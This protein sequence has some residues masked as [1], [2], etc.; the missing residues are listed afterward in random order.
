LLCAASAVDIASAER[1]ALPI[2]DPGALF[3]DPQLYMS[4]LPLEDCERTCARL[5]T[6]PWFPLEVEEYDS[7]EMG[8]LEWVRGVTDDLEG[9]WPARLPTSR[10][11][12]QPYAQAAV[13]F[14]VGFPV[15]HLILP[16]PLVSDINSDLD[17]VMLWIDAGLQAS[18]TVDL[19]R[20]ATLAISDSCLLRDGSEDN[21][22]IAIA[23]DQ[24]TVR[25]HLDGVYVVLEQTRG[26][27]RRL[28][29]REVARALLTL[30]HVL[31]QDAGLGV[32]VNFAAEFGM[33]CRGAGAMGF[34]GGYEN[35]G[36]RLNF[37]DF[38][39]RGGGGALPRFFSAA[40]IA[41][42]LTAT[43][44]ERLRD[45]RLLWLFEDDRT[46]AGE[47]LLDALQAGRDASSVLGWQEDLNVVTEARKHY[48]Q[49][50]SAAE[51]ELDGMDEDTRRAAVLQWLQDAERNASYL[52]GRFQED[53]LYES[54]AHV[55]VW[56]SAY[57]EYLESYDLI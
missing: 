57:E 22:I 48:L 53:P 2:Q 6:Y 51:H 34:A 12:I 5:A 3:F 23:I 35:K 52:N 17:D 56:R 43:D 32:F 25:E 45:Q 41:E 8:R 37:A 7:D 24:L 13:E 26:E 49:R 40:C 46:P 42:Y 29:H 1:R 11:E 27:S 14:Q 20:F 47:P 10:T 55:E 9:R 18:Q 16:S 21:P 36:R 31:G 50:L 28:M 44:L 38:V 15:S 39:Q 54:G 19:P 4:A 30:S 33:V